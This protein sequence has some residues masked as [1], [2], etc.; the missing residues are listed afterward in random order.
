M[1]A[2]VRLK[3]EFTEDEK[4]HILVSWLIYR[5]LIVTLTVRASVVYSYSGIWAPSSEFVSSSIPSWQILT[6]HA[7]PFRGARDLAFCLKVPLDSLR[8][9]AW[10]FAARIDD[11]YQIRLTQA[12]LY[13]FP[14]NVLQSKIVQSLITGLFYACIEFS[15]LFTSKCQYCQDTWMD[16]FILFNG[17]NIRNKRTE[18]SRLRL[19][20]PLVSFGTPW[21]NK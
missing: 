19:I 7:Q 6:A 8:R 16:I 17:I 12:I 4:C 5:L 2:H 15:I 1:A 3:N 11:K 10:T 21:P 9:L 20:V 14:F 18:F 13:W